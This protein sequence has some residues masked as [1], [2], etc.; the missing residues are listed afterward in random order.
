[1]SMSDI[2]KDAV[3]RFEHS[4]G[5]GI[6]VTVDGIMLST[7]KLRRIEDKMR[8]IASKNIPIEPQEWPL[9]KALD[10]FAEK[11][12][13]DTLR[14]LRNHKRDT[15]TMT[16]CDGFADFLCGETADHTGDISGFSLRLFY[17]GMVLIL[18]SMSQAI[19]Q[20]EFRDRPKL[21]RAYS[22][23]A[24]WEH[25]Q[26]CNGAADLNEIIER[27]QI[28]DFIRVS[29]SI[30]SRTITSI[31]EEIA[32]LGCRVVFIAGPSSSGK[33]TF[34]NRLAI[35]LR[36]SG[37]N[38][39]P[40]S[41]DNYYKNRVDIPI[42][43]NGKPD[44][45]CLESI[46]TELFNEQ[47][48]ELLQ[49]ETVEIPLYSFYTKNREPKGMEVV[50]KGQDVLIVE[51][52]HGLNPAIGTD[53]PSESKYRIYVGALTPI[54]LDN[55]N[56]LRATDIRLLRRLV[57]DARTRNAGINETLGM[58]D[59]VKIGEIK[60]IYPYME[61]ANVMFNTTL[62]YEISVLKPHVYDML[63]QVGPDS[64]YYSSMQRILH[65]LDYFTDVTDETEIP[66]ISILREFV[67]GCTFYDH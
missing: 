53:V 52:I 14:L 13:K 51:G 1:M 40:I 24:A 61:E 42:G 46:D 47:L 8:E 5:V 50:M 65:F 16:V 38:P 3:I 29:E 43:E 36:V 44:L 60:N 21:M 48:L 67:G 7:T 32:D 11:G 64:Q 66:P 62:A 37:R 6:F 45:E 35:E 49:G 4:L 9:Q 18:Q 10:Y 33:T 25:I 57:R 41:L 15:V 2:A 26:K 54:N 23:A 12:Q 27:G 63:L 30:Q 22:E 39:I 56:R 34:A 28:R 20:G 19:A 55:H 17:P 59:D 58:W 31:A